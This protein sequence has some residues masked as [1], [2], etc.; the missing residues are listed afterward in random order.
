MPK[1]LLIDHLL[2]ENSKLDGAL[3]AM[4][5]M[6]LLVGLKFKHRFL[7]IGPQHSYEIL[8]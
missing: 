4:Q 3:Y 1:F 5:F 8:L 6:S 2:V 7:K